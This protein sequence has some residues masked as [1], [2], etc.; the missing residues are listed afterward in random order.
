MRE[1]G[2]VKGK[3][4]GETYPSPLNANGVDPSP[5]TTPSDRLVVLGSAGLVEGFGLIGAEIHPDADE[6]R[7]EA[8]LAALLASGQA[9]LVLLESHLAH[10]G[11]PML[12]QLRNSGGRIVVTELPPLY[13]PQDYA[14]AV[15]Q[16]VSAVL[17]ADALK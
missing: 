3:G 6:A 12:A 4:G 8:V 15:D 14:P 11:G 5:F 16:V 2:R 1:G 10:G 9:A 7:V 17:G 13:A